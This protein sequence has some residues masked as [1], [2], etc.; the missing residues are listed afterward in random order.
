MTIPKNVTLTGNANDVWIFQVAGGVTQASGARVLLTGGALASN[1]FW[2][3]A[4]IVTVG[5]SAH[6]E[7]QVMSQTAITLNSGAT[8][9]G[10]LL[11]QTAV[12]LSGNTIVEQ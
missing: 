12:T 5:T 1:V 3:V 4:G 10:R 7:G 8:V 2:Q 6:M 11:A 9:N